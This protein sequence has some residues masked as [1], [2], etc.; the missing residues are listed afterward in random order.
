MKKAWSLQKTPVEAALQRCTWKLQPCCRARGIMWQ[1]Y[2]TIALP[3]LV[4]FFI[5]TSQ[6]DSFGSNCLWNGNK[7]VALRCFQ[8]NVDCTCN[9]HQLQQ[10]RKRNGLRWVIGEECMR[11]RN[12]E[13][14]FVWFIA[15]TK[16]QPSLHVQNADLANS[17]PSMSL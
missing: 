3:G 16:P 14:G 15:N 6:M 11:S 1:R 4:S 2:A 10:R 17:S 5:C 9:G 7:E 12:R 8:F 13:L